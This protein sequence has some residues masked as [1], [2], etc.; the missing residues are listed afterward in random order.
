VKFAPIYKLSLLCVVAWVVG[1][2]AYI[3][4]LAVLFRQSIS[5]GDFIAV[6]VGSAVAFALAFITLYLPALFG[7][8]RMLGGVRPA[9][10]FSV[11][12]MVLG[13]APTALIVFYWGGG[14]RGLISCEASLFYIM[15]SVV[16]L[17]IGLGYVRIHRK[18]A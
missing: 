16:G 13:L 4:A 9:W 2:V 3:G 1:V 14:L 15:F 6:L 11:L 12:A 8:Y 5:F 10:A 17:I 7:L 18:V